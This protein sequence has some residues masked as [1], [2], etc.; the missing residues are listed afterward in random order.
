MWGWRGK[1]VVSSTINIKPSSTSL[2]AT[3]R[4]G[5]SFRIKECHYVNKFVVWQTRDV[6]WMVGW[7]SCWPH[8]VTFSL[9]SPIFLC[10][11]S[12]LRDIW[13]SVRETHSLFAILSDQHSTRIIFKC[14]LKIVNIDPVTPCL[15]LK[16]VTLSYKSNTPSIKWRRRSLSI[17]GH[18]KD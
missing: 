18:C 11:L 15:P 13:W 5:W 7:K 3:D 8:S 14:I 4:S 17:L 9:S 10:P 12:W 6:M 16:Y 2:L 1:T